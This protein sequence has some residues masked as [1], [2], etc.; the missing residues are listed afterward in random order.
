MELTISALVNLGE[1]K[2]EDVYVQIYYGSLDS[3]SQLI[4]G[5]ALNMN[6]CRTLNGS[7]GEVMHEFC[8]TVTYNTT[9]KRGLSVRVIPQHQDL[10]DPFQTGLITW[11]S[12]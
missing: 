6:F 7:N 12:S 4:A 11:A 10:A 1:L 2:P 3:R 5:E 9:G 8:A